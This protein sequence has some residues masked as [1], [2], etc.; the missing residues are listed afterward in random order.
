MKRIVYLS[1]FNNEYEEDIFNHVLENIKKNNG[2]KIYYLLPNGELL[3]RYRRKFINSLDTAFDIN[4]STFDDIV[5]KILEYD[6]Y[7]KIETPMKNVII[8]DILKELAKKSQLEYYKD[9]INMDGFIESV[10]DIIGEI[11]RSL[12]CPEE[13][14]SKAPENLKYKE[15]GLIYKLY[16]ELLDKYK[17]V[18]REGI[19]FRA[20]K[21]L[22]ES[23]TMDK[24]ETIIIDQ[25]YNFRP[26]E[27]AI[28]EKLNKYN[29][30]II[31][32]IPFSM[33]NN[34]KIISK[35]ITQ[36]SDLGFVVDKVNLDESDKF[37][38]LANNI[39]SDSTNLLRELEEDVSVIVAD[40]KDLEI[41]KVFELIK[42]YAVS[43]KEVKNMA[44]LVTNDE[45]LSYIYK[46][47]QIE[48]I[49]INMNLSEE[50]IHQPLIIE[51]FSILNNISNKGE[52][53]YLLDRIKCSYFKVD[54]LENI[55]KLERN[56]RMDEFENI[57]KYLESIN[58]KKTINYTTEELNFLIDIISNI[59]KEIDQASRLKT[60][61]EYNNFI[62][63]Y[64]DSHNVLD[65]IVERYIKT[66][67]EI[68]FLRDTKSLNSFVEVLD[69]IDNDYFKDKY[70]SIEEYI[71]IL[72]QY[73]LDVEI[74]IKDGNTLGLQIFR[75][76]NIRNIDIDIL[77]IT[78]LVQGEYP[79]L[80]NNHYFLNEDNIDLL[81]KIGIDLN[82][83]LEN[84]DKEIINIASSISN[85]KNKLY[86]SYEKSLDGSKI[87]SIF[88]E[89]IIY[90]ISGNRDLKEYKNKITASLDYLLKENISE[91]TN[92]NDLIQY[93]LLKGQ[94][95][96]NIQSD[97][98][99]LNNKINK[100]LLEEIILKNECEYYRENGVLNE[101]M[102]VLNDSDSIKITKSLL[103][104]IY[105]IS[106][107][108]NYN[109]CPFNYLLNYLFGIEEMSRE[110]IDEKII[111][112]GSIYHKVLY[113][114][115]FEYKNILKDSI[116]NSS[117]HNIDIELFI[118]KHLEIEFKSYEYDILDKE[119]ELLYLVMKKTLLTFIND[120][121]D[122]LYKDKRIPIMLEEDFGKDK[123][124]ELTYKD[125][126]VKLRG[127]IDRVDKY[128]YHDS[129]ILLDYKTSSYGIKNVKDMEAGISYQLPIY[130][131]SQE[132][133]NIIAAGYKVIN[134]STEEIKLSRIDKTNILSKSN[135]G[136]LD[137]DRWDEL[138]ERV[139][140]NTIMS[141][142][143]ME[144]GIFKIKPK[145]CS[146][147]CIYKDI[148]RYKEVLE[149]E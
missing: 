102:G 83:Y 13:Y 81:L 116:S 64:I 126:T 125:N 94:K 133:K 75:P 137:M 27:I 59:K 17:Y 74:N 111:D 9:S 45:Y 132:D 103:S 18:D 119:I 47:S 106:Q 104:N 61:S 25:F 99:E 37:K 84:L 93:I 130:I 140:S 4:I 85:V 41:K 30:D 43:G 66:N 127:V 78:G 24:F 147:Y 12:I 117:E 138:L 134:N 77:F 114:F 39:F 3:K 148:C 110:A 96:S 32:N 146:D 51:I 35:T 92:K 131:L 122:M 33:K 112:V 123:I 8:K 143:D 11:K 21:I 1:S 135:M 149:V 10:G 50:L 101:Y 107:L 38:K 34:N 55:E 48:Q 56:L 44:I 88:I 98:L 57:N 2:D 87:P 14:I 82:T 79:I 128:I 19:Y 23:N 71:F 109:R 69:E 108:E 68:L 139:K 40:N 67:D 26:I 105:S 58:S 90:K 120:D 118:S 136:A 65:G 54:N 52:K 62:K 29:L 28:L 53:D 72:E 36:L 60:I 124:F 70:I 42:K 76:V 31:I 97:I 73:L 142:L 80:K 16:E 129:Y 95:S 49:P 113:K 6:D 100:D 5:T 46:Y 144:K 145:E 86:L 89:D 91:L 22:K 20:L 15:I 63:N 121:I 7:K 141:I 115:Y